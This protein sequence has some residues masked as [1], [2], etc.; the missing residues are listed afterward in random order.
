MT[1]MRDG[2]NLKLTWIM[3][4]PVDYPEVTAMNRVEVFAFECSVIQSV[5]VLRVD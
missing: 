5:T 1:S 3:H 4:E 2:P